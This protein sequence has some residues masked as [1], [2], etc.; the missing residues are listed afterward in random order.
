MG[1]AT[2]RAFA[3]EGLP[4]RVSQHRPGGTLLSGSRLATSDKARLHRWT[5]HPNY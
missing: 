3:C 4:A 1:L 2:A 5:F